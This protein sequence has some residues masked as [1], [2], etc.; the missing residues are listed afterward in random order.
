MSLDL[1]R[2]TW[3]RSTYGGR[4][5]NLSSCSLPPARYRIRALLFYNKNKKQNK[6]KNNQKKQTNKQTN[7]GPPPR[8]G[9]KLSQAT[10]EWP[11]PTE[12]RRSSG[13]PS[14]IRPPLLIVGAVWAPIKIYLCYDLGE[15]KIPSKPLPGARDRPRGPRNEVPEPARTI[16][17]S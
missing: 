16:P 3:I 7:N 1:R 4:K 17:G 6:T 5:D 2:R 8:M 11:T 9:R 12:D 13:Q 14:P 10:G 15:S